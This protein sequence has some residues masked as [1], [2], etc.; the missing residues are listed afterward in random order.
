MIDPVAVTAL[1]VPYLSKG[2]EGMVEEFGR[3]AASGMEKLYGLVRAKLTKPA[4]AEALDDL[5]SDT[6]NADRQAGLRVQLS[7]AFSTDPEFR[8]EIERLVEE[9]QAAQPALRASQ[10]ATVTGDNND[11]FQVQGNANTIQGRTGG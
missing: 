7:K 2:A 9:I 1:L 8:A 11:T 4:A 10:S 3:G 6:E 5:E